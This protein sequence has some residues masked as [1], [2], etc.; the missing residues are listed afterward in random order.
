MLIKSF[1]CCLILG[2][3]SCKPLQDISVTGVDGFKLGAVTTNGIKGELNLVIKNPNKLRF[4]IYKSDFDVLLG[5]IKLGKASLKKR[6]RIGANS[7]KSYSFNLESSL[8]N[9]NLVDIITL[10]ASGKSKKISLNG[11]LKIGKFL[12]RKKYSVN[13]S[14]QIKL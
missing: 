13:Y 14:G 8:E 5:N 10:V 9:V 7:E 3:L 1:C 12:L 6:V 11:N 4:T 2:L